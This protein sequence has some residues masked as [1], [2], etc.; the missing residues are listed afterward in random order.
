[1]SYMRTLIGKQRTLIFKAEHYI[2]VVKVCKNS[3]CTL[4]VTI[5]NFRIST[6]S[7]DFLKQK[8]D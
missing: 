2:V 7:F 8:S 5:A 6:L 3:Q 1:M 4:K